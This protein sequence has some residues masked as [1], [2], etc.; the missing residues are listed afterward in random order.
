MSETEVVGEVLIIE[1]MADVRSTK[2][3]NIPTDVDIKDENL[4][5]SV[6]PGIFFANFKRSSAAVGVAL[7]NEPGNYRFVNGVLLP[8]TPNLPSNKIHLFPKQNSPPMQ[9]SEVSWCPLLATAPKP[10]TPPISKQNV[11]IPPPTPDIRSM[12]PRSLR[13]PPKPAMF[14]KQPTSVPPG[15]LKET[16][17]QNSSQ[18]SLWVCASSQNSQKSIFG[19]FGNSQSISGYSSQKSVVSFGSQKSVSFSVSSS[20]NSAN[21]PVKNNENSKCS[22]AKRKIIDVDRYVKFLLNENELDPGVNILLYEDVYV[23]F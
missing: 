17:S 8:P 12:V 22:V 11:T 4:T 21:L 18:D 9:I 20:Q 19:S 10:T 13:P 2:Y 23:S 15:I 3:E 16:N 1:D 5:K 14:E 7:P 6:V